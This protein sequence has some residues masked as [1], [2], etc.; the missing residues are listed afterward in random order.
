MTL[1][2]LEHVFILNIKIKLTLCWKE[3]LNQT[4]SQILYKIY[5]L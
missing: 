1:E 3:R 2:E 5:P 4:L